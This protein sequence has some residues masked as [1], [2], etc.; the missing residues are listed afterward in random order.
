MT[1]DFIALNYHP[2]L[3]LSG[4]IHA[5]LA[6][7]ATGVTVAYT[8]APSPEAEYELNTLVLPP[9]KWEP[10]EAGPGS[11]RATFDGTVITRFSRTS[12]PLGLSGIGWTLY[13][14]A[15]VANVVNVTPGIRRQIFEMIERRT[16]VK[17]DGH[18]VPTDSGYRQPADSRLALRDTLYKHGSVPSKDDVKETMALFEQLLRNEVLFLH[19]MVVCE[20]AISAAA[21]RSLRIEGLPREILV[22]DE[23]FKY[24]R[25]LSRIDEEGRIRF[26][27]RPHS[28]GYWVVEAFCGDTDVGL[29]N[30]FPKEFEKAHKR[31]MFERAY[32]VR[33]V[34]GFMASH[35]YATCVSEDSAIKLAKLLVEHTSK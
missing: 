23:P 25:A 7:M 1:K 28:H 8:S 24:R 31:A 20:D 30:I 2:T 4:I 9:P 35:N 29:L 32:D 11:E 12:V 3:L 16:F 17:Y 21:V 10:Y 6:Q 5:T 22:L 26:V 14:D 13:G 27:V 33:G 18:D 19:R 15:V 34:I